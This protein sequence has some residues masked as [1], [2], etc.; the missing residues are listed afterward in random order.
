MDDDW[1]QRLDA[2]RRELELGGDP[3]AWVSETDAAEAW[4]RYPSLAVRG[5]LFGVCVQQRDAGGGREGAW[6]MVVPL[7]DGMPQGARDSLNSLL[8]FRAKD[9]T[10]DPAVRRE[11][12]AAVSLLER[13]PV[14]EVEVLDERYRVVR[15]D[16]L[17]R[18]GP[19]GLEPPRPTDVE[20]FDR[21][22]EKRRASDPPDVGFVLDPLRETSVVSEAL[23]LSLRSFDYAGN[24]YP[25]DVREDS[26]RAVTRHPDVALLP[27]TFGIVEQ[28][29]ATW[30]PQGSL[31]PSPHDARLFLYQSLIELWPL[32]YKFDEVKRER[33]ARA[34]ERFRAAGRA[35]E[36]E[37]D[38]RRF[39][40][41]RI[42]RMVRFGPDGPEPPR[43]SDIDEYEPMKM[44]PTMDEHGVV[45][46]DA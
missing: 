30:R 14:D 7:Q 28:R 42:E 37:V 15:G 4:L 17:A 34:A 26:R 45:H 18:S 11:L 25:A 46:F 6:R 23:R 8:W 20:P 29:G 9:D 12:L 39:R 19:D 38:G 21:S 31:L 13:E 2:M 44:H 3:V 27:T 24:R 1:R 5:A 10:D 32:M 43:P 36:L 16:E 33:Y 22:W 40:I 41:C 35:D